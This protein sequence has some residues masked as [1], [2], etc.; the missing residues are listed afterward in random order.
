[1]HELREGYVIHDGGNLVRVSAEVDEKF[2]GNELPDIEP[3]ASL[4]LQSA[5][6]MRSG[7]SFRQDKPRSR[8]SRGQKKRT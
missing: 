5:C 7:Y 2:I 8:S 4:R 3:E 6:I 1:M